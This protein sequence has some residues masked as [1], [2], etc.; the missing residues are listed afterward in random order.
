MDADIITKMVPVDLWAKSM[1][2]DLSGQVNMNKGMDAEVET[3]R[4]W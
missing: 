1:D 2:S 4:E 3:C